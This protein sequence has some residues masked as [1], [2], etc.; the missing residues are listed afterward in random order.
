MVFIID[1]SM[2]V[3]TQKIFLHKRHRSF[4]KKNDRRI[5]MLE[6]EVKLLR[7]RVITLELELTKEKYNKPVVVKP[8]HLND[9]S[10]IEGYMISN[11]INTTSCETNKYYDHSSHNTTSC[12]Y[13]D[14]N[15]SSNDSPDCD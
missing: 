5:D 9:S 6:L 4:F 8:T 7:S 14:E 1:T 12:D 10:F 13:K 3:R 11:M 2:L 15:Y